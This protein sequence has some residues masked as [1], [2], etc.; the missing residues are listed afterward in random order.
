MSAT[1][2]VFNAINNPFLFFNNS[3]TYDPTSASRN[4]THTHY[5]PTNVVSINQFDDCPQ[6]RSPN[7]PSPRRLAM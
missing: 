7:V 2:K 4:Q 3:C 5:F 1:C 6:L